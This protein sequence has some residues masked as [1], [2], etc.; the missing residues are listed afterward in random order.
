MI[1]I[2]LIFLFQIICKVKS[3]LDA[4]SEQHYLV[5]DQLLHKYLVVFYAND[6][7]TYI[8][9]IKGDRHYK[10]YLIDQSLMRLKC[11]KLN[12]KTGKKVTKFSF[13]F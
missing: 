8:S 1:L 5:N 10:W 11:P 12:L 2:F 7:R 3:A 13:E 9:Q 6:L 4:K